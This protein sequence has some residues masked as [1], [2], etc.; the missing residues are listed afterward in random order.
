MSV[1]S[2]IHS[3]EQQLFRIWTKQ[4]YK[5]YENICFHYRLKLHKPLIVIDELNARWGSWDVQ[6]RVISLSA[7]LLRQYPWDAVLE[8]FKHE[9][10][11]QIVSELFGQNDHTHGDSFKEACQ[12][13]G[14]SDWATSA[15]GD[16]GE[17]IPNWKQ[18]SLS[19]GEEK[20]LKR[21]EKLLALASSTNEHEALLA[22]KR[23][24]ELYSRYNL[25]QL[26]AAQAPEQVYV[27]INEGQKRIPQHQSMMASI[28]NNHFFVEVIFSAT[29]N[30]QQC[31]EQKILEIMGTPENVQM[32][33]YVY[34]F[35]KHQLDQL[36]DQHRQT[37]NVSGHAKR[38]FVL[39]VLTGFD[40]KL[41]ADA[42]YRTRS[43][44]TWNCE[45]TSEVKS[46]IQRSDRALQ[47]YVR[48][49]HP[50]LVKR[51][52]DTSLRDSNSF[53][54]GKQAGRQLTIHKAVTK[55]SN[56]GGMRYL[57]GT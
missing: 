3:G 24:R 47:E 18:R 31:C 56:S 23:V 21:A 50:R 20:L 30:A 22:M 55:S 34:H 28:L 2:D 15:A 42:T 48:Y 45:P 5:E 53:E 46:L 43:G 27:I 12:I 38:S 11:H 29:Y 57:K 51:S 8:I 40:E 9:M 16:I 6:K 35:L 52:W 36:W 37:H 49:R 33:E 1:F 39:G 7:Q 19:D 4:L 10:A 13:L 41:Q 26:R 44:G 17:A 25:D 32:A 14:M 54:H